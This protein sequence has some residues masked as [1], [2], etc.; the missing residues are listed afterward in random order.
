MVPIHELGK[1]RTEGATLDQPI[2]HLFACHRRIEQ[3]LE[4]LERATGALATDHEEALAVIGRVM[5]F[6]E[7][8]GAWHTEDEEVSFFPRLRPLLDAAAVGYLGELEAQHDLV[9]AAVA[10]LG[11]A[12]RSDDGIADAAR[13]VAAAYR[14]HIQFEESRLLGLA[15]AALGQSQLEAISAEMKQR[16]GL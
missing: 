6:L 1:C 3:R 4:T 15:R 9:E 2:E 16:R 5:H 7:T 14:A 13:K 10:V 11:L 12:M 8:N